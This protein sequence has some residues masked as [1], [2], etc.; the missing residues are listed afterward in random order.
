MKI[1][2]FCS[3]LLVFCSCSPGSLEDYQYEGEAFAR[4][5]VKELKKI[6]TNEDLKGAEPLLKKKFNA[7]VDLMIEAKEFQR[8]HPQEE[9]VDVM[10]YNHPHSEALLEELK[11][12]YLIEGGREM[13]EKTQREA[14]I[15]LDGYLHSLQKEKQK[16]K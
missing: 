6:Q 11:R 5:L 14:L 10:H 2:C 16:I 8:K 15:R 7:L 3:F 13:V 9:E 1:F 12:V 4:S